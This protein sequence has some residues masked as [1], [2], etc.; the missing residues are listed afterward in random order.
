M[1]PEAVLTSFDTG[2]AA[3][4]HNSTI[5]T[6]IEADK[7]IGINTGIDTGLTQEHTCASPSPSNDASLS[8]QLPDG[9]P[10]GRGRG[11][12]EE[13]PCATTSDPTPSS[14]LWKWFQG[15]KRASPKLR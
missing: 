11:E 7:N 6:S 5:D 3:S 15:V 8:T 9:D 4:V 13:A 14:P 10:L 12:N 2:G 1:I